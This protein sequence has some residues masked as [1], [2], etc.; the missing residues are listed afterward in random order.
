MSWLG[1][2]PG[3]KWWEVCTLAKSYS[4]SMFIAIWNIYI[5]ARD[6]ILNTTKEK[7]ARQN[8]MFQAYL[9]LIHSF[10]WRTFTILY[11]DSAGLMRLQ[12]P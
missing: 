5:R 7:V 10:G 11:E 9:S 12:V 4:N 1:M 6:S 2:E 3:H 8:M